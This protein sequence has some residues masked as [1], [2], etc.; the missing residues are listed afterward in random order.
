M[1]STLRRGQSKPRHGPHDQRRLCSTPDVHFE[2]HAR[3]EPPNSPN[4]CETSTCSFWKETH[5]GEPLATGVSAAATA[6]PR[7]TVESWTASRHRS[8]G[9]QAVPSRSDQETRHPR[10]ATG[11]LPRPR[12]SHQIGHLRI[13]DQRH[14]H[15]G[16]TTAA[17]KP[18]VVSSCRSHKWNLHPDFGNY[19]TGRWEDGNDQTGVVSVSSH[20][21]QATPK[22]PREHRP[23]PAVPLAAAPASPAE[24][25]P[26]SHKGK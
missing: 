1:V 21:V 17:W 15:F 6:K 20:S 12:V 22:A 14:G 24:T 7:S 19:L 9:C 5:L 4:T 13:L 18:H 8:L 23:S 10:S 16:R 11:V 26:E 25:S 3:A 2:Q